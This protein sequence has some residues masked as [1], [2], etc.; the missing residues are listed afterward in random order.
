MIFRRQSYSTTSDEKVQVP[1]PFRFLDT[2]RLALP[3][4]ASGVRPSRPPQYRQ[5]D[6]SELPGFPSRF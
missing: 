6:S 3:L 2:W 5:Q 1:F 4:G